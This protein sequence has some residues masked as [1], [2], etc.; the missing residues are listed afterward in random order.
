MEN[1]KVIVL[2]QEEKEVKVV[3]ERKE[4]KKRVVPQTWD[5]SFD[6]KN[7]NFQFSLVHEI[8]NNNYKETNYETKKLCQQVERK[9]AGY[10]QQ[11][12]EKKLL[13]I[14]KFITFPIMIDSFISCD[15]QC[16]YCREKMFV[17]YEMVREDKQ[18]T[19]DRIDNNL[20]H[21]KDNFV[22]ACLSCNLKRRCRTKD[23]FLFTKQLVINKLS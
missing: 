10:K 1:K 14:E 21:N 19:V 13:D 23:K 2:K 16:F 11:D 4:P 5:P 12:I 7:L 15:F 17:L 3:K 9:I 22:L 18:W 6:Y 20:G 8:K